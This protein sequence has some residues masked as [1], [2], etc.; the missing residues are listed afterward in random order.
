MA[1]SPVAKEEYEADVCLLDRYQ[2]FSAELLRL[3]LVG[4]G[5]I[6][7]MMHEMADQF[8]RSSGARAGA[9]VALVSLGL[10]AGGALGHR[11]VS[12]DGVYYHL[13]ALRRSDNPASVEAS[14]LSRN[15]AYDRSARLLALSATCLLL[16]IASLAG[17]FLAILVR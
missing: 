10:A 15:R 6:G 13:R 17:S 9:I 3:A 7:F 4:L 11:Y 2:N 8:L 14:R 12:T 16:G 1:E 5:A